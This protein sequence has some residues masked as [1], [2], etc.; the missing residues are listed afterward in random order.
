MSIDDVITDEMRV[1][2]ELANLGRAYYDQKNQ[3]LSIPLDSTKIKDYDKWIK[4]QILGL[5]IDDMGDYKKTNY[6]PEK[7]KIDLHFSY[8]FNSNQLLIILDQPHT[9]DQITFFS[10]YAERVKRLLKLEVDVDFTKFGG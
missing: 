1:I 10:E 5:V 7:G 9:E 6:D 2:R 4:G 8:D 3:T